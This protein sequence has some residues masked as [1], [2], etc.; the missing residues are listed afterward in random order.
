[1]VL[2]TRTTALAF[3]DNNVSL[4]TKLKMVRTMKSRDIELDKTKPIT[5]QFNEVYE[6]AD[7]SIDDFISIQS[8]KFFHRF[9]IPLDFLDLEITL[10]N[11]NDQYKKGKE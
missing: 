10:W 2:N 9:G 5:L 3:F 7:K 6:Y 1:V 4:Q 11:K 8:R